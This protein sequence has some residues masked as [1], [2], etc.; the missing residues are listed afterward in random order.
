MH[1]L[2]YSEFQEKTVDLFKTKI[3]RRLCFENEVT[4]FKNVPLNDLAID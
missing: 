3:N 1:N 2:L 4:N